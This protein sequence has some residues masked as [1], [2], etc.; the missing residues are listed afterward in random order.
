MV[1]LTMPEG[2]EAAVMA[3]F[4][5]TDVDRAIFDRA[6]ALA[7]A[8]QA[9]LILADIR[10]QHHAARLAESLAAQTFLGAGAVAD[11]QRS[12]KAQRDDLIQRALAAMLEA[13]SAAGVPAEIR[14]AKGTLRE[15]VQQIAAEVA[16]GTVVIEARH[17]AEIAGGYQV[18]S[19]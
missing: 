13:A 2:T 9:R 3:V 5:G 14:E 12:V 10:H 16:A 19:P 1:P 11:L 7:K 18:V 4:S 8:A 17:A 15:S 6:L